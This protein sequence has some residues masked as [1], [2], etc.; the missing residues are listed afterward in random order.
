MK[1]IRE[2][3]GS[4]AV[5]SLVRA[6]ATVFLAVVLLALGF[7]ACL[8]PCT[9]DFFAKQTVATNVSPFSHDSLVKGANATRDYTFF[10]HDKQKLLATI[11]IM[12]QELQSEKSTETAGKTSRI[13]STPQVDVNA[14]AVSLSTVE[15]ENSLTN[16]NEKYTLNKS[17]IEHLDD[18]YNVVQVAYPVLA[19]IFLLCVAGVAHVVFYRGWRGASNIFIVA[20]I[21]VLALFSFLGVWA[22]VDFY[23]MF[24]ALHSLLFSGG[25]W[26]F[27][28]DSL[29]ICM[30]PQNFWIC[31][32]ALWLSTSVIASIISVLCGIALKRKTS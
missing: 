14:D 28:I 20:G 17:A 24:N 25:S 11:Y 31:L 32:G 2:I 4:S 16:A 13:S 27:S 22:L 8:L 21:V 26:L 19:V 3:M 5:V 6:G 9:T 10:S 30:L 15:L 7:C 29:L 12:N 23:S 1:K 18:V